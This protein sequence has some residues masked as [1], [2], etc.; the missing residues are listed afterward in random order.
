VVAVLT[1]ESSDQLAQCRPGD[2]VTL[3]WVD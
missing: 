3:V 1:E 2:L